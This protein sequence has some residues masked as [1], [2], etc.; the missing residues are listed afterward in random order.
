MGSYVPDLP[1]L[2][3]ETPCIPSQELSRIAG[4]NIFLK[5]EN[6]QPSGSF[7]SR[8]I[9]TLMSHALLSSSSS[10]TTGGG[11]QGAGAARFYC[12]SGGNAGLA[13]AEAARALRRPCDVFLPQSTPDLVLARLA[14]LGATP[15]RAGDSW[16]EADAACREAVARDP[17]GVYVPPFDDPEIWNGNASLV[18]ELAALDASGFFAAG[19]E[20]EEAG[21]GE[22]SRR[23]RG[24]DAIVCNVGGG[25][26]LN[27]IMEGI[28]RN[29]GPPPPPPSHAND[30]ANGHDDR[31][32]HSSSGHHRRRPRV[33]AIETAGADSLAACIQA[34]AHVAIPAI[35]SVATTLGAPR[36]SAE[37]YRWAKVCGATTVVTT[38]T[39]TT[40][41]SSFPSSASA[42]PPVL[43]NKA[44]RRPSHN[45]PP[46][47]PPPLLSAVVSDADA[48][49]ACARFLDDARLLV[50]VSCGATLS[51]VYNPGLLRTA[52]GGAGEIDESWRRMNVVL[53]VCGGSSISMDMLAKYRLKF[54]V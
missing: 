47:P 29:Y 32:G 2:Y 52:L 31:N 42:S 50:E 44:A 43:V 36:V 10:S 11:G 26:L 4:C 39:T 15:H 21:E 49:S 53:V 46:P 41:T 1:K 14:L 9:G 51:S 23:G 18:D 16:P 7:K 12:S 13:C 35:T 45:S 30:V 34:G 40:T 3:I 48:V 25:G 38:T 24:I 6:L 5:L 8:G 20:E 19:K 22:G 27:G 33:L 37:T 54:G 28:E 17:D